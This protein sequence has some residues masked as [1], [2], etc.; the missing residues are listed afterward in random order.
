[1]IYQDFTKGLSLITIVIGTAIVVVS[2]AVIA[3]TGAGAATIHCLTGL[4]ITMFLSTAFLALSYLA[5]KDSDNMTIFG[6]GVVHFLRYALIA[7]VALGV[8]G[9][10][11]RIALTGSYAFKEAPLYIWLALGVGFAVAIYIISLLVD[12]KARV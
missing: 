9:L 11:S 12:K 4:N 2:T 8:A 7:N 5:E 10:I 6:I 3:D 1:M